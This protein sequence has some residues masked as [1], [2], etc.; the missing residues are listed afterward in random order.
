M[1]PWSKTMLHCDISDNLCQRCSNPETSRCPWGHV[2][3]HG[4]ITLPHFIPCVFSSSTLHLLSVAI[5]VK[6][7]HWNNSFDFMC[8]GD[9]RSTT[10]LSL[11]LPCFARASGKRQWSRSLQRKGPFFIFPP[12]RGKTAAQTKHQ[13]HIKAATPPFFFLFLTTVLSLTLYLSFYPLDYQQPWL[14]YPPHPLF[15]LSV[16]G[17]LLNRRSSTGNTEQQPPKC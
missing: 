4:A 6:G 14:F 10:S 13:I 5:Y 11:S 12:E 15:L 9:F 2:L 7:D 3:K 8:G 17:L 16:C 1:F